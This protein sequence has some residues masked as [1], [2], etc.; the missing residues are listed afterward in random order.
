MSFAFSVDVTLLRSCSLWFSFA[1]VVDSYDASICDISL[2][3]L[4]D[5]CFVDK[6]KYVC[7]F[8]FGG[9]ALH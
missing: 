5:I 8:D 9:H 1:F 3:V 7:S 2:P 6:R 4:V